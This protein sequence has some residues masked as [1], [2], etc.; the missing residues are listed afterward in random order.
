VLPAAARVGQGGGP[1]TSRYALK[2]PR[3]KSG[4]FVAASS[5]AFLFAPTQL[6][7]M[8]RRTA[9]CVRGSFASL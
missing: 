6:A 7:C 8:S 4:F 9:Y 5:I 2:E 3:T 1:S